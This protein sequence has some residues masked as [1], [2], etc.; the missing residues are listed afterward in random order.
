MRALNTLSVGIANARV[1]VEGVVKLATK[2]MAVDVK[3]W[4]NKS[5]IKYDVQADLWWKMFEALNKVHPP[6]TCD[7]VRRNLR[8]LG[9]VVAE[10]RSK[11]VIH[12]AVPVENES[13]VGRGKTYTPFPFLQIANTVL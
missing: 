11:D 5:K 13:N 2:F 9:A 10:G 8:E 6:L 4:D 1:E 12:V 3:L 7:V